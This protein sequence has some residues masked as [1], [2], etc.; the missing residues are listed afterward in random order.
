MPG[1]GQSYAGTDWGARGR[2]RSRSTEGTQKELDMVHTT[3]KT[4]ADLINDIDRPQR[5]LPPTGP[6]SEHNL[7]HMISRIATHAL[8]YT[9]RNATSH[10]KFPEGID[11]EMP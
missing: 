10:A 8:R 1:D 4:V 9:G 7:R 6:G 2:R 5:T 3:L 11:F